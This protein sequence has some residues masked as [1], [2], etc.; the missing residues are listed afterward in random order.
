[1]ER[2]LS[3]ATGA[4]ARAVSESRAAWGAALARCSNLRARMV[5]GRDT[6]ERLRWEAADVAEARLA[7]GPVA[8]CDIGPAS[9]PVAPHAYVWMSSVRSAAAPTPKRPSLP[10]QLNAQLLSL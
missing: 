4:V 9:Q 2:T 3:S 5:T 1:M 10:T 7:D 8:L 6:L